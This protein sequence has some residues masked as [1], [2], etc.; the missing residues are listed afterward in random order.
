MKIAK[1]HTPCQRRSEV[2]AFSFYKVSGG[3][4]D[5]HKTDLRRIGTSNSLSACFPTC[6]SNSVKNHGLG[7]KNEKRVDKGKIRRY[8]GPK[9]ASSLKVI[10]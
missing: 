3:F 2:W 10:I 8:F 4:S 6:P 7:L 5:G 1:A 9:G